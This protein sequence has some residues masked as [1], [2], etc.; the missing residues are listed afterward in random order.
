M[1]FMAKQQVTKAELYSSSSLDSKSNQDKI[2]DSDESA[3]E[4]TLKL[5][6]FAL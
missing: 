6:D 1:T 5:I 3:N 2:N 4:V